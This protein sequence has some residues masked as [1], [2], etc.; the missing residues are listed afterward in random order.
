[1]KLPFIGFHSLEEKNEST[2]EN[3]Y[4]GS[5]IEKKSNQIYVRYELIASQGN[6]MYNFSTKK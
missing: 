5:Q 1:M 3:K 2:G 4:Y 6:Q